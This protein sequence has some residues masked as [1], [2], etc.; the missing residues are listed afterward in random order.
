ML[1]NPVVTS[2]SH[3]IYLFF[4]LT[5]RS[6]ESWL[7]DQELNPC[8]LHWKHG[9][10]RTGLPEKSLFLILN[11]LDSSLSFTQQSANLIDST[12]TDYQFSQAPSLLPWSR[13]LS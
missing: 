2:L 7:P 11:A 4:N 10:L 1:L 13:L 3:F 5:V 8:S 6:V 12:V 9:V